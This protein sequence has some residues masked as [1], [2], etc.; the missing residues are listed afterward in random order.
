MF[1]SS[2]DDVVRLC[3]IITF[4]LTLVAVAMLY[5]RAAL[6][7]IFSVF[8]GVPDAPMIREGRIR[9]SGPFA[10][11]IL[12]GTVGAVTLPLM[13]ALWPYH[14]LT[15]GLGTLVCLII[16]VASAS[17]GPVM[18]AAFAVGPLMMWRYRSRMRSIRWGAGCGLVALSL[19]MNAPVYYLIARVD[20]VGGSTG[21]YRSRLIESAFEHFNEW[22]LAG[23][24]YTRH[25]MPENNAVD[26]TQVDIT[27]YYLRMGVVGGLP[28]ILIFIAR[29]RHRVLFCR[30]C[31]C[32]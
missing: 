3:R 4:V 16:V 21:W 29:T 1:C 8:G 27:N 26:E 30:D 10:H 9:A 13:I 7:N 24:D 14:P 22:W 15:A 17:S 11:P 18:S 19:V 12:A 28:L 2:V 20:I 23:T 25:W 5:E 6:H 32:R 31:G